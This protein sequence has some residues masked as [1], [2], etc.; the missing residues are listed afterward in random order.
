MIVHPLSAMAERL[1]ELVDQ[2]ARDQVRIGFEHDGDVQVVLVS[3]REYES[4]QATIEFLSDPAAMAGVEEGRRDIEA[5][6][7]IDEAGMLALRAE[8]EARL[9]AESRG[10]RDA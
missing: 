6:R 3:R 10:S 1:P 5:G 9:E 2:V 4:M 8:L 7:V